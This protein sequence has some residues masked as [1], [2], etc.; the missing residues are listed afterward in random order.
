MMRESDFQFSNPSLTYIRFQE[1]KDFAKE[2]NKE[3]E[4][5]T[6]I[7]IKN[8][9]VNASEA[10]VSILV[11]IGS[12]DSSAP[13]FLETEFGAAFKWN[14]KI[15]GDKV[16]I[17]LKQNAPALLLSYVRPIISMI[18][19]ISHYPPYDLPFINFSENVEIEE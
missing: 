9:K 10:L 5:E 18:T 13:F 1:N 3:I 19:N 7:Q 12:E 11:T 16:D 15:V 17:F 14:E 2:Q 6:K 4:L 8:D